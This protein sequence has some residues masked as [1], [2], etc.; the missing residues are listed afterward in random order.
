LALLTPNLFPLSQPGTRGL[1]I[2][3]RP[4]E[5]TKNMTI[6]TAS[7]PWDLL[8]VS[9]LGSNP[10]SN[11][12]FNLDIELLK[13]QLK[14]AP[15][16]FTAQ[17]QA[18]PLEIQLPNPNGS[19]SRFA[20]VETSIM[21][22]ELA[23]KYPEIKTYQGRSLD[24][25][26][27]TITFDTNPSGFYA[28]ILSS[29]GSHTITNQSGDLYG[30]SYLSNSK[31]GSCNCE[32]CNP[33]DKS[34][35]LAASGQKTI[36]LGTEPDP[37]TFSDRFTDPSANINPESLIVRQG[38]PNFSGGGAIGGQLRIYDLAVAAT[39][40]YTALFGNNVAN[41]LAAITR[42]INSI[43]PLYEKEVSVRMR[44]VANN[45]QLIYTNP[46]TDPYTNSNELTMLAENQTNINAV[47]GSANYDIGHVFGVG[48]T[49]SAAGVASI[50]VVGNNTS[51]ARGASRVFASASGA[52]SAGIISLIAHEFGHQF[53]ATHTFN[54]SAAPNGSQRT[55][56]SAYEPGSGSSL[57]SYAGILG[58]DN[59]QS[60]EDFIFHFSSLNQITDIITSNPANAA[61]TITSNGNIIPSVNAG[62]DF[63]IPA[64]TPFMLTATG[65][66]G[67][68]DALTY[69]WEQ[70]DLGSAQSLPL[71]DNGQSPIFRSFL[72][73]SSPTRFFPRLPDILE[74]NNVPRT[75]SGGAAPGELLPTTTRSLNFVVT[76][77]D[78]RT[79]G[80]AFSTDRA[81]LNVIDTGSSFQVTSPNT[82]VSFGGNSNQTVTWN[83]AGTNANGIN[84][85]NVDILLSIDGGNTF[86]TV[87]LANTPNDGSQAIA[88]P[89]VSTT[90]ARIMVKGS[91]N[92]FF[93]VSNTNFTIT[94]GGASQATLAF[95]SPNFSGIEGNSGS[96]VNQ[97][98][99]TIQRLGNS[100]GT[101]TV[102][103]NLITTGTAT[104][105][106][107]FTNTFPIAVSFADGETSKNVSLGIIGD[108]V[109]EENETINLQ[110]GTP[111]GNAILGIQTTSTFT[112]QNDDTNDFFDSRILLSGNS[113]TTT[114]SNAIATGET[115]E[116]DHASNSNPLNSIWWEW[117][118]PSNGSVTIN[119][120]GSN[121]DTTLGVYTGTSVNALTTIASNDDVSGA[122]PTS[123]ATF[124]AI[125]NTSYKIAVDGFQSAT[126]GVT[127]GLT[128]T[129]AVIT[130]SISL[131]LSPNSVNEDG[132]NNLVYNFTRAGSTA[133]PLNGIN[134]SVGG[135]AT[136]STDYSQTGAA[137]FNSSNGT[138]NF[139]AGS[140]SANLTI[141]PSAD[142]AVELDETIVITL[143]AGTDYTVGTSSAI[144][145]IILNDDVLPTISI[146]AT[147][148]NAAEQNRDPG[149][150]TVTRTGATTNSL[151]VNFGIGGTAA[152]TTDY[153]NITGTLTIPI[154]QA[155]A[156]VTI[157][158][159]D[160]NLI[161]QAETVILN[162]S[163]SVN[164][165]IGSPNNATVTITDNDVAIPGTISFT[166]NNVSNNEGN[167]GAAVNQVIATVQRTGGSNG[168]I[169]VPI[170]LA[171]SPGTATAGSDYTN[172]FPITVNFGDGDSTNKTVSLP[173]IGDT[174]FEPNETINLLLGNP[175]G[176]ASLGTQTTS[177]Y[178]ILNDDLAPTGLNLDIDANGRV[179]AL[180]DGILAIRYLF[181]LTGTSLT[182]GA[183][184][185]GATRT[186]G[187][188]IINYLTPAR[189][190]MLDVDGNSNPD[191][192][193]DG[194]LMIRYMFGLT[195]NSLVN[196]AIGVGATRTTGAAV[197][198][199]LQNYQLPGATSLLAS[200]SSILG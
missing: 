27:A 150:F 192:L 140:T 151:I 60:D 68:G 155:S 123:T 194:I 84:A 99:A 35:N 21:A 128:F 78:N 119:T 187:T 167:S 73:T 45:D 61:A 82:T 143:A 95:T 32:L 59:I 23:A 1:F 51:K 189:S 170:Q 129:P 13:Q 87:L 34:E 124:N 148:P 157:T 8:S 55:A 153:D 179:D 16:E 57:M 42:T 29:S 171:A 163:N 104:T 102:P 2:Y 58:S 180:T 96:A 120:A 50:G 19:F 33:T 76:A 11:S 125:A 20:V 146:A 62:L 75:I 147:D 30:I 195:D 38:D 156:T 133:N 176:G 81:L 118:A 108:A 183:V 93:D 14:A 152:N 103:V 196:G 86:P 89:N 186:S 70:F 22:P 197:Q 66:D 199:F 166:A 88:I 132:S 36:R 44:L 7:N 131:S 54:G 162:L 161:E 200:S 139:A 111:T 158:P 188:D 49:G 26:T 130:T 141:D 112:I 46:A 100:T 117:V 64:R 5:T 43:N 177:T 17:A 105:G 77:R 65:S 101:V 149:V 47:I 184:G 169:S 160:D 136:L 107:D 178:T 113:V 67:N 25:P 164:Y 144:T 154:G 80:G 138:I 74:N 85:A 135:T 69:S 48:S 4:I 52:E 198:A 31:S 185:V 91:G 126:G 122:D 83:V 115:G 18:A 53:G 191:A 182:N 90:Q 39:G 165:N 40:E 24:D 127:L 168:A 37:I 94:A 145:G 97:T 173:I 10:S 142:T 114:G 71:T 174:T 121:F 79:G 15:L 9:S 159:V 92:V 6:S 41:T 137:S 3:R 12:A 63:T 175:T 181:G 98:I 72:P 134:F 193:T 106:T 116:P 56:A 190:S 110:L 172:I 28:Q 109:N